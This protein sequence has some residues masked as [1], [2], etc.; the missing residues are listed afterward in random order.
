MP[1]AAFGMRTVEFTVGS[2]Q[3]DGRP[4]AYYGPTGSRLSD[5]DA[6]QCSPRRHPRVRASTRAIA[7][8]TSDPETSYG[9][10]VETALAALQWD[11]DRSERVR[12]FLQHRSE[13]QYGVW[14]DDLAAHGLDDDTVDGRRGGVPRRL[15]RTRRSTS[16]RAS[17]CGWNTS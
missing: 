7:I 8:A 14:I 2:Y 17:M 3:P 4:I 10:A 12:E 9:D 11:A 6:A 16:P 5:D 15:R 1:S 13:E